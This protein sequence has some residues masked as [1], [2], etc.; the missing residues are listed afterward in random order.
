MV[1]AMP[2][3]GEAGPVRVRPV[4]DLVT[5][6]IE[7]SLLLLRLESEVFFELEG[8]G[9]RMWQ[10]LCE[11]GD[12]DAIVPELLEEYDVEEARLRR[13][14]S[15]LVGELVNAGLLTSAHAESE[16]HRGLEKGRC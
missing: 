3:L 8:V 5:Q 9:V 6:P 7:E 2:V 10:L 12:A 16:G 15:R 1:H 11:R 14:L 4:P 13:D